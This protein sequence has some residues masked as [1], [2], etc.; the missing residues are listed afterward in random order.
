VLFSYVH[1][2]HVHVKVMLEGGVPVVVKSA[3]GRA[4]DR[5]RRE[6][7]RL[8]QSRHPGVVALAT[9]RA[10]PLPAREEGDVPPEGEFELRTLYAGEPVSRWAGSLAAI[11]GVG[12][13]VASTLADLHDVGIV[14]G[15]VDA[16]HI[17]IGDD[18]RPRLCG[19]SHPGEATPA[20]DVAALGAVLDELVARARPDRP[21]LLRRRRGAV[22]S[23]A[24]RQ[25]IERA[26]D[27]VVTRRPSARNLADAILAAVPLAQLPSGEGC[28]RAEVD[29]EAASGLGSSQPD[30]LDRI[31]GL[32]DQRSDDERWA[33]AFGGA[34]PD[35]P[36]GAAAPAVPDLPM[37]V[38]RTPDWS[39]AVPDDPD[40]AG[41]HGDRR[42]PTANPFAPGDAQHG[43]RLGDDPDGVARWRPDDDT[44]DA[45]P[46][47]PAERDH[48]EADDD[49]GTWAAAQP[50]DPDP[51]RAS[52]DH[53]TGR[54]DPVAGRDHP[55]ADGDTST[56]AAAR[57]HESHARPG[58]DDRSGGRGAPGAG[59]DPWTWLSR[60]DADLTR[61]HHAPAA[62]VAAAGHGRRSGGDELPEGSPLSRRLLLVATG[63][64]L[65]GLG[66][67]AGVMLTGSGGGADTSRPE[68]A[69]GPG[70]AGCPTVAP[71]AADVDRD[72]CP[73]PLVIDG[74]IVDAG[75]AQWSLGEPGDL[76][77]L[78][79][80]DCDGDA[81]AALLRPGT[82]DVF[83]FSAWA[84]QDE[85]VTVASTR[86]VDSGVGLRAEAA[87]DGCDRLV[88]DLAAGGT[89]PIEVPR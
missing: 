7:D 58:S 5:L 6:R 78:G 53:A 89:T 26:T 87:G 83:V 64:T 1:D 23:R 19:L 15:R 11:A 31:W 59:R 34:P 55:E 56:W 22:G 48:P 4:A 52:D 66:L 17:L 24:L 49:T 62:R 68:P 38:V 72:G 45:Q 28:G 33:A 9:G 44:E 12:A 13:A 69:G 29:S 84:P 51:R 75:V 8:Q 70:A 43:A 42:L 60:D 65:A 39:A 35:R 63:S 21:G 85:P 25:V 16:S 3:S 54:P 73:E 14:H 40:P 36:A 67:A 50:R 57:A 37:A 76:V 18:G 61:D 80:W 77:A 47:P 74:T 20:D 86:R 81:S 10:T 2:M 46:D 41:E 79:D 27:P 88:V 32:G 82:G 71:P 30:T